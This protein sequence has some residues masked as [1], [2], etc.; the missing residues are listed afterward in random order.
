[1]R[2]VTKK[3]FHLSKINSILYSDNVSIHLIKKEE[4]VSSCVFRSVTQIEMCADWLE[5]AMI[6][7]D[8]NIG[9]YEVTYFN[10]KL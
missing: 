6:D 2:G 9:N 3:R 1:M 10:G 4:V 8:H 5:G 7:E